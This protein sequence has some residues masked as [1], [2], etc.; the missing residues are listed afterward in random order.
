MS[1]AND[2]DFNPYAAPVSEIAEPT[3]LDTAQYVGYATFWRRLG[4]YIIDA[5]ITGIIGMIM[6]AVIGA[7]LIRPGENSSALVA[8]VLIQILSLAISWGY[9]A[10]MESSAAQ[11]TVGKQ[12]LGIKVTDLYGQRISFG[13]ATGRFFGKIVS[14]LTL[15][16]G[17]L[18]VFW[19]QKKQALHDQMASTLVL[20]TR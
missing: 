20:R 12:A 16:I 7:V 14:S 2:P 18:M 13:R 19:T 15:G 1:V 3:G 17:Y 4:A 10:G 9:Y 5:I 8:Q 11:A 6:G